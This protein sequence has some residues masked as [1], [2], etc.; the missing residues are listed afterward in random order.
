MSFF[1]LCRWVLPL[2]CKHIGH[3]KNA[4]TFVRGQ[5]KPHLRCSADYPRFE[6]EYPARSVSVEGTNGLAM[7]MQEYPAGHN[8]RC[9]LFSFIRHSDKST[10][11]ATPLLR[12][13][14]FRF[15]AALFALLLSSLLWIIM[16]IT[17][18]A[19]RKA[20]TSIPIYSPIFKNAY[21]CMTNKNSMPI[22]IQYKIL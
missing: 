8:K 15:S 21:V 6:R 4:R 14:S 17:G 2:R 12:R 3:T 10:F 5:I 11:K 9:F 19:A 13:N 16:A 1:Y 20:V 7:N 22:P 18:V